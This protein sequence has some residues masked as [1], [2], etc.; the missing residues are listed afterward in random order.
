MF[1]RRQASPEPAISP[2]PPTLDPSLRR[3][4]AVEALNLIARTVCDA[5]QV[6]RAE[7]E[8][9]EP[10][11]FL[12]GQLMALGNVVGAI[13]RERDLLQQ[14]L[15]Q[16][17]GLHATPAAP[18]WDAE[19]ELLHQLPVTS[20]E[21]FRLAMDFRKIE[22]DP[23]LSGELPDIGSENEVPAGVATEG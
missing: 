17:A 6:A 16:D 22:I 1:F 5:V 15:V 19:L 12:A 9:G 2:E 11:N 21:L 7:T 4:G 10:D 8:P 23:S 18:S 14:Q 13:E 3:Q 20:E